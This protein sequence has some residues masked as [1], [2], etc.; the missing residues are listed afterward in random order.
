MQPGLL[1][2]SHAA[3]TAEITARRAPAH[4]I[5]GTARLAPSA[6]MLDRRRRRDEV[7]LVVVATAV[8]ALPPMV[9]AVPVA[10]APV[11]AAAVLGS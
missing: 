1:E 2:A 6:S 7:A 3:G 9:V 10:A 11:V 8:A 4:A 5:P